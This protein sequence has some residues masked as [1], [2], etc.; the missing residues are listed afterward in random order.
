MNF[1]N[2]NVKFDIFTCLKLHAN[3]EMSQH[4]KAY[5]RGY[6]GIQLPNNKMNGGK[7]KDFEGKYLF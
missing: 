3:W 4:N 5:I 1:I 2:Y 6:L 7:N